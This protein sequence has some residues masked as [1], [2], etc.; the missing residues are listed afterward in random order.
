MKEIL[1][2]SFIIIKI[3]KSLNGKLINCSSNYL[4]NDYINYCKEID[5]N[6]CFCNIENGYCFKSTSFNNICGCSFINIDSGNNIT[7]NYKYNNSK[8]CHYSLN[9]SNINNDIMKIEILNN[10]KILPKFQYLLKLYDNNF[11]IKN[12]TLCQFDSDNFG[13]EN[14]VLVESN[15]QKLSICLIFNNSSYLENLILKFYIEQTPIPPLPS[16]P[17]TTPLLNITTIPTILNTIPETN[18]IGLIIGIIGG[19][20]IVIVISII[21]IIICVKKYKKKQNNNL[22]NNILTESNNPK[23]LNIMKLNKDKIDKIFKNELVFK[24]YNKNNTINNCYKCEICKE[25]FRENASIVITTKCGHTFHQICIINWVN[26]NIICPKCPICNNFVLGIKNQ[27]NIKDKIN[28]TLNSYN[29]S[30]SD[31]NNT[32]SSF[33]N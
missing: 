16:I 18:N 32:I 25:D 22:N 4:S 5:D 29:Q 28:P 9:K 20:L 3:M 26:K 6:L 31:I 17:T 11:K 33:N 7:I 30:Q 19:I 27:I 15:C 2:F 23:Y 21:I 12:E 24:I 10:G 8:F 1:L 14:S 13:S